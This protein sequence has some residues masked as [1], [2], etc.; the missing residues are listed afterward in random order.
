MS[1]RSFATKSTTWIFAASSAVIDTL[2][3]TAFTAHS[4]LRPRRW[5]IAS[6]NDAVKFSI[7]SP[8]TPLMSSPCPP[9]GCAAPMFVPGAMAATCP[10]SVM[11]TPAEPAPAPL[12]AT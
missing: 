5:A 11:K 1:S 8:R 6:L 10:A 7:F 12:G 4:T 3:R 2:S 9:T